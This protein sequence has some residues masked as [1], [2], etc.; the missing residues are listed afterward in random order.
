[1]IMG[2]VLFLVPHETFCPSLVKACVR[3]ERRW[4]TATAA[5]TPTRNML[6][7]APCCVL[8]CWAGRWQNDGL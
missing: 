5:V 2:E 8:F 3:D 4:E 7:C 6:P 1:M